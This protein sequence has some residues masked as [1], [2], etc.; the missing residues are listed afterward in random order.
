[1]ELNAS[2]HCSPQCD[3]RKGN[4]L[5]DRE[6]SWS[7]WLATVQG[8]GFRYVFEEMASTSG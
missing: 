6:I 3:T 8:L 2:L 1:M 4:N 7:P 5:D